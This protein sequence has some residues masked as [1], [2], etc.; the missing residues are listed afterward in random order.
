MLSP[1]LELQ[2]ST[3][4]HEQKQ[5]LLVFPP[6]LLNR[7]KTTAFWR[8]QLAVRK[9]LVSMRIEGKQWRISYV[10]LAQLRGVNSNRFRV[11]KNLGTLAPIETTAQPQK[12]SSF[13]LLDVLDGLSS[14]ILVVPERPALQPCQHLQLFLHFPL[15]Q[16]IKTTNCKHF[17]VFRLEDVATSE[18]LVTRKVLANC[19]RFCWNRL[20]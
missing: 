15:F 6:S 5:N 13:H 19:P 2:P 18:S 9:F 20:L 16:P 3:S 11:R 7:P 8:P 12:V 4:P 1:N 10:F 17:N 14:Q